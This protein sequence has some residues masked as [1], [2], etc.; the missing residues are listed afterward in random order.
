MVGSNVGIE[1]MGHLPS[2]IPFPMADLI[3]KAPPESFTRSLKLDRPNVSRWISF[4]KNH[5]SIF[6]I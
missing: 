4:F 1:K 6:L 5:A 3:L 2:F